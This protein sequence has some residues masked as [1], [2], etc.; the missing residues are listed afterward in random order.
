M[1]M[2]SAAPISPGRTFIRN[3][4]DIINALRQA[5]AE[6]LGLIAADPSGVAETLS[7][8]FEL[9]PEPIVKAMEMCPPT[10]VIQRI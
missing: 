6:A 9:E 5:Q 3:N 4:S 10:P 7:P 1:P 8:I 2:V